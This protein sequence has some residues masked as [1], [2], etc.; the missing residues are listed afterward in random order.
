VEISGTD[1]QILQQEIKELEDYVAR[2]HQYH[3][4]AKPSFLYRNHW[5]EINDALHITTLKLSAIRAQA[6]R[7]ERERADV[8]KNAVPIPRPNFDV[9]EA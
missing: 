8:A 3:L 9:R 2:V 1:F 4:G 5:N 6:S 7:I